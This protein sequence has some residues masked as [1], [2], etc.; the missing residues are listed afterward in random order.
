MQNRLRTMREVKG[1]TPQELSNILGITPEMYSLLESGSAFVKPETLQ[2]LSEYYGV[3]EDFLSGKK[4][5]LTFPVSSWRKDYQQ[6]YYLADECLKEYLEHLHGKIT[7]EVLPPSEE[8]LLCAFRK[9][10]EEHK[11]EAMAY[12]QCMLP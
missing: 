7:F 4:Y 12:I 11:S 5:R 2:K 8:E 1:K 9:L 10:S 3:S 6:D